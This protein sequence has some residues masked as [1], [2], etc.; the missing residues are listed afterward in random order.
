MNNEHDKIAAVLSSESFKTL[1]RVRNTIRF[2]L[3]FLV[4]ASHVFFVGGIAF[5]NQW[6]GSP[7]SSGSSIPVGIVATA[8]IIVIMVALEYVYIKISDRMIDPLQHKA[9]TE[10]ADHV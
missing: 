2:T 1:V 4:L 9:V 3:S 5:Y 8:V 10:A 6:F 7:W